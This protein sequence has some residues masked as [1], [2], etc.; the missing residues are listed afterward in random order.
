MSDSTIKHGDLI[1]NLTY[2]VFP[3]NTRP[4]GMLA[5]TKAA[6][7]AWY[8]YT[9]ATHQKEKVGDCIEDQF[10]LEGE[11]WQDT[12]YRAQKESVALLYGIDQ[13]E[14]D[15]HW[16]SVEAEALRIGLPIPAEEIKLAHKPTIIL[17]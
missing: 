9:I 8:Y 10:L 6:Q 15:A 3:D 4:I 12:H 17:Q 7:A 1:L 14:M 11:P 16:I 2:P 5:Q 13:G